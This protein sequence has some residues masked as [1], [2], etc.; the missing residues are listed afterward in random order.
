LKNYY[1][2]G[3]L[4]VACPDA[5]LACG[6]AQVG[7]QWDAVMGAVLMNVYGGPSTSTPP[8]CMPS[9][10]TTILSQITY[11]ALGRNVT[12][13]NCTLLSTPGL[14]GCGGST[15]W[16]SSSTK[17]SYDVENHVISAGGST[18]DQGNTGATDGASY[19]WGVNG[20]PV[21]VNTRGNGGVQSQSGN[22]SLFWDGDSLLYTLAGSTLDDV[23][24]GSMADFTPQDPGYKGIT[25]YDRG[26]GGSVSYCHN[27][28]GAGGS[29]NIDPY[30]SQGKWSGG[31]VNPCFP[32][33]GGTSSMPNR[34]AWNG[35]WSGQT[36]G[37]QQVPVVGAGWTIGEM[38][39]DGI[40][41]GVD[42]I[43]G[44]RN[45]DPNAA[46]WTAP[47]AYAG[48][49]HDPMS[50]KSYM[51]NGNNPVQYADPSGYLTLDQ[52]AAMFVFSVEFQGQSSQ[53]KACTDFI[54]D[55]YSK[56]LNIDLR[57]EVRSDVFSPHFFGYK[58]LGGGSGWTN[59]DYAGN[60]G[61]LH[62]F[63]GNTGQLH[64]FS[65]NHG[66]DSGDILFL[67][68]SKGTMDHV[69]MVGATDSNGGIESVV[70][71]HGAGDST[72][73]VTY[74]QFVANM[75]QQGVHIDSYGRDDADDSPGQA[76]SLFYDPNTGNPL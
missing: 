24:I 8:E 15:E 6:P 70:E 53:P 65:G 10:T 3:V 29:G 42:T 5:S 1:A 17:R 72:A 23:K 67:K 57:Q 30:V 47:D 21:S 40:S 74:A 73:E 9:C 49:V 45:Y 41:N 48:D 55:T 36:F 31:I 58:A 76:Q 27:A 22:E 25:F 69:A 33:V 16:T 51:W 68:D 13:E 26:P 38:R 61:N 2:N 32:S 11:D 50:Q 37:D 18:S 54:L 12:S 52:Q 28:T 4:V 43:Q 56:V 44:V 62:T 20:H 14:P 75:Q 39:P 19:Q 46:Q 59:G 63:F 64:T 60:V 34:I 35:A 7:A 66:F 71:S